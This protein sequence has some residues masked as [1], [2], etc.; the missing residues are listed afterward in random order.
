M[1]KSFLSA[2]K[3]KQHLREASRWV[4]SKQKKPERPKIEIGSPSLIQTNIPTI[5]I[6]PTPESSFKRSISSSNLSNFSVDPPSFTKPLCQRRRW[7]KLMPQNSMESAQTLP[8]EFQFDRV[9]EKPRLRSASHLPLSSS[10]SHTPGSKKLVSVSTNNATLKDQYRQQDLRNSSVMLL[11]HRLQDAERQL[12][13]RSSEV[14][15]LRSS[16][17][18]LNKK[19][20][21]E[22]EDNPIKFYKSQIKLL[23]KRIDLERKEHYFEKS[24]WQSEKKN[25]MS[26]QQMLQNQYSQLLQEYSNGGY[27]LKSKLTSSVYKPKF[28]QSQLF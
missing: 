24:Q 2:S 22:K 10:V 25:V 21:L 6:N 8:K 14:V 15:K 11:Q 7:S 26:Y 13:R 4:I 27:G 23:Q 9:Q 12:A 16:I 28:T 1:K 19:I 17:H 18:D 5:N 3:W 20:Y